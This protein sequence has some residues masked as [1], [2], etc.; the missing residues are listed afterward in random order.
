MAHILYS[1]PI[2][3][4]LQAGASLMKDY[5]FQKCAKL[6]TVLG[7]IALLL[8]GQTSLADIP[9]TIAHQGRVWDSASMLPLEGLQEL[10]FVLYQDDLPQ[11]TETLTVN[12]SDGYYSVVLGQ[13]LPIPQT[14]FTSSGISLGITIGDDA[15]LMPRIEMSSV[16]FAFHAATSDNVTGDITPA[17]IYVGGQLVVD[18]YGSWVGDTTGLEGP[19]GPQGPEG[20]AGV[21][22]P[23]GP[24][25]PMGPAGPAG[26]I[27]PAGPVGPIGPAGSD[28]LDGADGPQGPR[29]DPGPQGPAGEKG[30]N[31][32]GIWQTGVSY[33]VDDV[34]AY[35]GSS[36]I[37]IQAT[38][39]TE[40][41]ADT[42]SW[43]L[44]AARGNDGAEG[45][46]GPQGPQGEVGPQGPAGA[47]GPVG[48]QGPQG[49]IGPE[50]PAGPQGPQG[51]VGPQGPAGAEGPVGPQGPQGEIGLDGPAGPQ[52]PQGEV[53]PQG[54]AGA[55]GPVG[56][57]GPQGP[58]GPQGLQGEVGSQGPTGADGAVGPQGPQGEIGPQGPA[59]TGG[60]FVSDGNGANIGA[61][62]E[63]GMSG[64]FGTARPGTLWLLSDQGY[65]FNIEVSTGNLLDDQVDLDYVE[66]DECK[67]QGYYRKESGD[68]PPTSMSFSIGLVLNSTSGVFY[69]KR[70]EPLV[71]YTPK[72]SGT[73]TNCTSI[74]SNNKVTG[75]KVYPNDP[76][77]TGV[78]GTVYS[79][80][81]G[82]SKY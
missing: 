75:Y 44:L 80:P 7:L 29:G 36:F 59:G 76:A 24:I 41:P 70:E 16:P 6:M 61:F 51:E 35:H 30:A 28:G 50:G 46:V 37:C 54:P 64:G 27:G 19:A 14:I 48:P 20:P 73:E 74:N 62:V 5:C 53:G 13:Q 72:S 12:F 8:A 56:P 10:A 21:A 57:Q 47:E 3:N 11:W 66:T 65:L 25:G 71:E 2:I 79:T 81:I 52:G 55:E 4:R 23:V 43:S 22:G 69:N 33:A 45:A 58:A 49:E 26:S 34:V 9:R 67:G 32:R 39:G 40:D 60:L 42:F 15:E 68:T 77:M 38:T 31:W 1:L 82:L 63:S 78:S 17:S 18:E